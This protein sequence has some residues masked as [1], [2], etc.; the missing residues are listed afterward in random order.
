M[1][2]NKDEYTQETKLKKMNFDLMS[3]EIK[4]VLMISNF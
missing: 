4:Q 2:K 3:V 1:N